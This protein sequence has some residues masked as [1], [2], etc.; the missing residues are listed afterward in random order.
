[1]PTGDPVRFIDSG[2]GASIAR[3]AVKTTLKN[4]KRWCTRLQLGATSHVVVVVVVVDLKSD[5]Q[6]HSDGTT[7]FS[8]DGRTLL[9]TKIDQEEERH[10]ADENLE[11]ELRESL[12]SNG[13]SKT[14]R[15]DEDNCDYLLDDQQ[16]GRR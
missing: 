16:L 2:S 5:R 1:M 11:N 3:R 15:G 6:T 4:L 10:R 7:K 12:A 14:Y 8:H 13:Q 9:I